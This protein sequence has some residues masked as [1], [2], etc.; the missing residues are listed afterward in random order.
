MSFLE[1]L[2]VMMVFGMCMAPVM[3]ILMFVIQKRQTGMWPWEKLRKEREQKQRILDMQEQQ[4]LASL[5]K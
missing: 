4:L 5:K 3:L 2:I 1:M